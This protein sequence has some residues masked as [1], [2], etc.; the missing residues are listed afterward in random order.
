MSK[1]LNFISPKENLA[2][3]KVRIWYNRK[4]FFKEFFFDIQSSNF[5]MTIVSSK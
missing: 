3:R 1:A 2:N 5:S 4:K